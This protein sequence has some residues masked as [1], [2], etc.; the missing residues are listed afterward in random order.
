M[1]NLLSKEKIKNSN[2]S[3]KFSKRYLFPS[4]LVLGVNEFII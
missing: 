3:K 1:T 4:G 2:G